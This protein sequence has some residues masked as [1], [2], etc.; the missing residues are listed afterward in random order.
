M[1]QLTF[2][3]ATIKD[4]SRCY[5]I[6]RAGYSGDEAAT[7]KKI[8][9]RILTYPEGFLV[10]ENETELVGFINGGACHEVE[11][12]DE[13]FK[14]LIGH[15]PEGTHIVVM[16]LVVHP[17]YQGKGF[18]G[19]LMEKFIEQMRAMNKNDIYLICQTELIGF[20]ENYGFVYLNPSRSDHGGLAWH[21]MLLDL[22]PN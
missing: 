20:Y 8:E 19:A 16:S 21:D 22:Q 17:D 4:V 9:Q 3:K 2:R 6:E 18:A 7:R 11:L 12:S 10:A 5:V 13:D 1:T 14:D 15:D